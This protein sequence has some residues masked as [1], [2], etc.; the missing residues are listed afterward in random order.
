MAV[1]TSRLPSQEAHWALGDF[2]LHVFLSQ[3]QSSAPARQ[4]LIF[5][6]CFPT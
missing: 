1:P 4:T 6:A 3:I 5:T 2:F